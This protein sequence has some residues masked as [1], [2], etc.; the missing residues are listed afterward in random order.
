MNPARWADV[1]PASVEPD[2]APGRWARDHYA[3]TLATGDA[4]PA[5]AARARA[6]VL[7]YRIFPPDRLIAAMPGMT[8]APGITIVQGIR[9][10]VVGLIAAV[11]V[12]NV[13]DRERDGVR[14]TGFSYVTLAGHPERGAETFAVVDDSQRDETRFEID[15]ISQPGHWLARLGAPFARRV[16]QAATRA[17]LDRMVALASGQDDA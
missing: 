16:Q 15:A 11:R 14:R 1:Q 5:A 8:V 13:F 2:A 4:R 3:V 17:A 10:G 6:A 7:A 12:V 9:L